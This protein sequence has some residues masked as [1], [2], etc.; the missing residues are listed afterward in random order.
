M[1]VDGARLDAITDTR[2]P[3]RRGI[4]VEPKMTSANPPGTRSRPEDDPCL[5]VR[6]LTRQLWADRGNEGRPDRA[7]LREAWE[8]FHAGELPRWDPPCD[9]LPGETFRSYFLRK[10]AEGDGE[11][12][13]QKAWTAMESIGEPTP[14]PTADDPVLQDAAV[15]LVEILDKYGAITNASFHGLTMTGLDFDQ[16]TAFLLSVGNTWQANTG[17][18]GDWI[19]DDEV[20]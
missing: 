11:V 3:V 8:R 9:S 4:L 14:L 2:D 20:E 5:V 19:G 1:R 7:T 13:P 18:F 16:A 12:A 6:R 17:R 10:W 15:E